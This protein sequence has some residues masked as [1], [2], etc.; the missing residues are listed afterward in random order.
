MGR[1]CLIGTGPPHERQRGLL[2]LGHIHLRHR[3]HKEKGRVLPGVQHWVAARLVHAWQWPVKVTKT[4]PQPAGPNGFHVKETGLLSRWKSM[5][6]F[7]KKAI[8][9]I[10]SRSELHDRGM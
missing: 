2:L 8:I 9:I 1:P 10:G 5:E 4:S 7:H 6:D 3:P